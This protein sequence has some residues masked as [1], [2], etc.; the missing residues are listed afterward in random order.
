MIVNIKGSTLI[1]KLK[2]DEKTNIIT[3]YDTNNV[4]THCFGIDFNSLYPHAFS[5]E[6]HPFI[7]YTS[8][9]MFMPG[10]IVKHME[11]VNLSEALHVLYNM[12]RYTESAQLFIVKLKGFIPPT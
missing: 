3:D 11:D 12:D 5:S 8:G 10:Y 2:F 1:N 9:K 4:V 6:K 7:R